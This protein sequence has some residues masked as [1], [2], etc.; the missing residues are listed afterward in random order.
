MK[1]ESSSQGAEQ[2]YFGQ[3]MQAAIDLFR[4]LIPDNDCCVADRG[5]RKGKKATQDIVVAQSDLKSFLGCDDRPESIRCMLCAH[6][7]QFVYAATC[8]TVVIALPYLNHD[9]GGGVRAFAMLQSATAGLHVVG[10]VVVGS[11]ND[12]IGARNSL[13]LAHTSRL[14]SVAVLATA[15]SWNG[16][17]CAAIPG[18]TMHGFQAASQV[19]VLCSD[20]NSRQ[21]ALGRMA[22]SYGFGWLG[23][24][25]LTSYL[26][27][28]FDSQET[29]RIVFGSEV[30]ILSFLFIAYPQPRIVAEP[31]SA[32]L[33]SS[34]S[35][36][37]S[38]KEKLQK[39][40]QTPGVLSHL[41]LK[42][43]ICICGG[44]VYCMLP[45]Y[46]LDPFH[47]N[48]VETSELMMGVSA[49]QLLSQG[50]IVPMIKQPSLWQLQVATFVA[51]DAPLF[52]LAV[53][54]TSAAGFALLAAPLS[55]GWHCLNMLIN[56]SLTCAVPTSLAGTTLGLSL[57]PM[58]ISFL[59]APML[60]ATV[61][62]TLGF[63]CVAGV[64]CTLLLST[65]V[66]VAANEC[67][68]DRRNDTDSASLA[69]AD[70]QL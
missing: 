49:I 21:I 19:A 4:A 18:L 55:I 53:L 34:S 10:G 37:L 41:M 38:T 47:F 43:G 29:L 35:A 5:S 23:G 11:M 32:S 50:V 62:K 61:F 33:S 46:A 58:T 39:I 28:V 60:S 15:Q 66:A 30:V 56:T 69:P 59:V 17:L 20:Q 44:V 26:M 67:L 1:S 25:M 2:T 52:A 31:A 6:A 63:P 48:A 65:Q 68:Q 3:W 8:E 57:A 27:K 14:A 16:L 36:H 22:M 42:L 12:R 9:F 24:A 64:A 54:P 70:K 51:L 13:L 40:L 45:Q 7:S